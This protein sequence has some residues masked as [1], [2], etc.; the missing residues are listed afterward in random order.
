MEENPKVIQGFTNAIQKG[1]EYV[2]THTAEEIAKVI[3]PQFPDTDEATIAI[4]VERYKAQDTWKNDTIFEES[5]FTL[6]QDILF[7]AGVID[8]YAPY[9]ELVDTTYSKKAAE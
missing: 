1:L 3:A 7:E 6:L 5:S 8:K 4:I 9:S 2:N